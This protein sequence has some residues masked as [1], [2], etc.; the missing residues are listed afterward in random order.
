MSYLGGTM[1]DVNPNKLIPENI[2]IGL[3]GLILN[4]LPELQVTFTAMSN[5][6]KSLTKNYCKN[7]Q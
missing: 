1:D 7:I 6:I 4:K 3:V 2:K 5:N